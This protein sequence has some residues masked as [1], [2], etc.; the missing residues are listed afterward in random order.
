MKRLAVLTTLTALLLGFCSIASA[1]EITFSKDRPHYRR[2]HRRYNRQY[3]NYYC[4]TRT[5][6]AYY[7]TPSYNSSYRYYTP[8]V[9][10]YSP[11]YST[12]YD[13]YTVRET[14]FLY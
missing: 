1:W 9:S 3:R 5:T 2:H 12:T 13:G 14:V 8:T 6:P 10:Y 4:S 7:Y 11:Y